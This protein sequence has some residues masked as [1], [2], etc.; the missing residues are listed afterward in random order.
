MGIDKAAAKSEILSKK[1]YAIAKSVF[2]AIDKKKW[3]TAIKLSKK[4]RDKNL[5]KLVNYL[6][7]IKPSNTA[8][9][10]DYVTFIN[11]NPNF[12]AHDFFHFFS[13]IHNWDNL[14]M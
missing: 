6:H 7:L 12:I 14:N 13:F 3:Q 1:D 9:F 11:N 5:F 8:S 10:Y 2:E 4:A